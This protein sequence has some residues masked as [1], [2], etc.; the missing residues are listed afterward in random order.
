MC[1]SLTRLL[2]VILCA[3]LSLGPLMATPVGQDS[4][5][6]DLLLRLR[7][8][9][10]TQFKDIQTR[11]A[12]VQKKECSPSELKASIEMFERRYR[13][14]EKVAPKTVVRLPSQLDL[15]NGVRLEIRRYRDQVRKIAHE[16][17]IIPETP[18]G[19]TRSSL[20]SEEEARFQ[21]LKGRM[22]SF[23]QSVRDQRIA[24]PTQPCVDPP[25]DRD[26]LTIRPRTAGRL[27]SARGDAFYSQDRPSTVTRT[28]P[29]NFARSIPARR[30]VLIDREQVR[31]D[32]GDEKGRLDRLISMGKRSDA[33]SDGEYPPEPEISREPQPVVPAPEP[34]DRLKLKR[35]LAELNAL[36]DRTTPPQTPSVADSSP[37]NPPLIPPPKPTATPPVPTNSAPADE[38]SK[39]VKRVVAQCEAAKANSNQAKDSDTSSVASENLDVLRRIFPSE[40]QGVRVAPTPVTNAVDR[41]T[42]K[43]TGEHKRRAGALLG[44]LNELAEKIRKKRGVPTES[45][46]DVQESEEPASPDTGRTYNARSTGPKRDPGTIERLRRLSS[47]DA[48]PLEIGFNNEPR[49]SLVRQPRFLDA[50][51]RIRGPQEARKGVSSTRTTSPIRQQAIAGRLVAS[52]DDESTVPQRLDLGS[53]ATVDRESLVRAPARAKNPDRPR[54][55][56]RSTSSGSTEEPDG[57]EETKE[58]PKE[59]PTPR[60]VQK[61]SRSMIDS[62]STGR[63]VIASRNRSGPRGRPVQPKSIE[64]EDSSSVEEGST[65][66]QESAQTRAMARLQRLRNRMA[67]HSR[68]KEARNPAIRMASAPEN[69]NRER[70]LHT[71]ESEQTDQD[72]TIAGEDRGQRPRFLAARKA[73]TGG[74]E[75]GLISHDRSSRAGSASAKSSDV[76]RA[77]V[78]FRED[79]FKDEIRSAAQVTAPPSITPR[80][81]GADP[82]PVGSKRDERSQ[83]LYAF[84]PETGQTDTVLSKKTSPVALNRT[85]RLSTTVGSDLVGPG[86][87]ELLGPGRKAASPDTETMAPAAFD[88]KNLLA[89]KPS[90]SAKPPPRFNVVEEDELP[91]APSAA[92]LAAGES[93]LAFRYQN[94][95]VINIVRELAEEAQINLIIKGQLPRDSRMDLDIRNQSARDVLLFV[96][97]INNIEWELNKAGDTM[98]LYG[99]GLHRAVTKTYQFPPNL[100]I[101][102]QELQETIQ[103]A[104]LSTPA[105]GGTGSGT[106]GSSTAGGS[107]TVS[108]ST[109]ASPMPTSQY[110]RSG[111]PGTPP[112]GM[113]GASGPTPPSSESPSNAPVTTPAASPSTGSSGPPTTPSATPSPTTSPTPAPS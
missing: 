61:R 4:A 98:V 67:V 39:T 96:L 32:R 56:W 1:Q 43:T 83:L 64:T 28:D 79:D 65:E 46:D 36:P 63:E 14:L 86:S 112:G 44:R 107:S 58:E 59:E 51:G 108:G 87:I 47:P 22:E 55:R 105:A 88:K 69:E 78:A 11:A 21:E 49:A 7:D 52:A 37:T 42:P 95:E 17:G 40:P 85:E 111:G 74:R 19:N 35:M 102:L 57:S 106:P 71:P 30:Q 90:P 26:G 27:V 48:P 20:L 24:S 91:G 92:S 82:F 15:V 101:S 3:C 110:P 10:R 29:L 41:T 104:I 80:P 66:G 13:S 72:N 54:G 70:R 81:A 53:D 97:D 89:Q 60:S 8:L 2:W 109:T 84:H 5:I 38:L 94:E 50:A 33:T 113:P 100:S 77:D 34:A 62:G 73:L 9:L 23:L 93:L 76:S 45:S 6:V 31:I 103:S 75:S 25:S 18:D 68:S 16:C 12:K 99:G